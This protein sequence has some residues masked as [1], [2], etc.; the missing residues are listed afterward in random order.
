MPL[1]TSP[2]SR[3]AV[4]ALLQ[5]ERS[6]IH[7]ALKAD[8]DGIRAETLTGRHVGNYQGAGPLKPESA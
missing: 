5:T 4:L 2:A 7:A 3:V 1:F 8:L 6:P